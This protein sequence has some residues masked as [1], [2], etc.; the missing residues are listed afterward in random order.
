MQQGWSE[1][2]APSVPAG[3]IERFV[4][5]Q[6]RTVGKDPVLL[7]QTIL[8]IQQRLDEESQRLRD[9]QRSLTRQ[10]RDDHASLQAMA[11]NSNIV[12]HLSALTDI[13]SRIE[14]ADYRSQQIGQE[15]ATLGASAIDPTQIQQV[16]TSF[17]TLW[18]S[19][20]PREQVRLVHLLVERVSFD[21]PGENVAITFHPTG[22][23]SLT[24]REWEYAS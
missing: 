23:M 11:A 24:E 1:C 18:E 13:R 7:Q 12:G 6:I 3:E 14:T 5:D 2:P 9:E 8:D 20:P 15:L 4:I 21:G 10:I 22:L 16:L 17:D 19:L